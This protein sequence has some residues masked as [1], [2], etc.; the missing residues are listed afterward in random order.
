MKKK[1]LAFLLA[2]SMVSGIILSPIITNTVNAEETNNVVEED[3]EEYADYF[4]YTVLEDGTIEISYYYDT[5]S[6]GII[7]IPDKIDGMTVTGIKD[8]LFNGQTKI[9]SI[10]IP[11]S[12]T[13]IGYFAFSGCTNLESVNIPEGLTEIEAGLFQNCHSLKSITIPESVTSIAGYAFD[14]C[15]SLTEITIPKN[16]TTIQF[17]MFHSCSNLE[18]I[19][20]DADNQN[21]MSENGILYN[22][23]KTTLLRCPGGV[24]GE[25]VIGKDVTSILNGALSYCTG[26]E[27]ITVEEGN[28]Y[29]AVED[30]ALIQKMLTVNTL[31]CYPAGKSGV[32]SIP[33]GVTCIGM[34]AFGGCN[35]LESIE[36]P[37]G[38]TNIYNRAFRECQN[39]ETVILP[40][41]ITTIS[42]ET[43]QNC[44]AL[45]NVELSEDVTSIGIWAFEGCSALKTISIPNNV[46]SI[47]DCAFMNCSSLESITIPNSV[48]SMGESVF[49]YCNN[50]EEIII[51]DSVT[52]IGSSAFG[53]CESLKSITL[54][55]GMTEITEW[56]LYDC[57]W[58]KSITIPKEITS[59]KNYAFSGCDS[60]TD[61]YYSGTT[62]QWK[63]VLVEEL[64][65]KS[66]KYATIHC[67]DGTIDG[68]KSTDFSYTVLDN[69]TVEITGLEDLSE[70][71]NVIIPAKIEGKTVTGIGEGAFTESDGLVSI[72][73]PDTVTYIKNNA[74]SYCEGLEKVIYDGTISRWE[75]I[76][77]VGNNEYLNYVKICCTDGII[78]PGEFRYRVLDDGT[79]EVT[80]LL[81][82]EGVTEL[83]IPSEIDGKTVTSIGESAFSNHE[84]LISVEMPDSITQICDYAFEQCPNLERVVLS[85]A[86]TSLGF[87]AFGGSEKLAEIEIPETVTEI[88]TYALIDTAWLANQRTE[89]PLVII[90]GILLDGQTAKGEVIIPDSVSKIGGS[91]FQ[92]CGEMTKITIPN[93]V[94][95][96]G[97]SAFNQCSGL[98][99]ITIPESVTEIGSF[100]FSA[101]T[102]LEEIAIPD[103]VTNIEYAL[104]QNCSNLKKVNVPETIT[105]IKEYAF[106]GCSSLTDITIPDKVTSIGGWA[107]QNCT[108][109]ENIT[110][111]KAVTAIGTRAFDGTKWLDAKRAEN[112]LVIVN[113]IVIDGKMVQGD[114]DMP[115]TVKSICALAFRENSGLTSIIIPAGIT[116][117][118]VS[119][120]HTCSNLISIEIPSSVINIEGWAFYLCDNLKDIYY[121]GTEEQWKNIIV[122]EYCNDVLANVTIH[123]NSTP[124]LDSKNESDK[125]QTIPTP[126]KDIQGDEQIA[127]VPDKNQT[128]DAPVTIALGSVSLSKSEMVYTGKAQTPA[129]TVF[130]ANNQPVD[131]ANYTAAYTSNKNVGQATV[132][133]TGKN[134]YT[135][136]LTANFKILPKGTKLSKLTAKKKALTIK[137]KKQ[138]KQTTGYEIQYSTSKKFKGAKKVTVKKAK[139][140]S[141]IIKKLKAKKKYYV[142]IR[143]YKTVKIDGKSKKLYSEWSKSKSVKV[144]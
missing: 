94:V 12:V 144:K 127:P 5:G 106:Y 103:T 78:E 15:N 64:E 51:S 32:V 21:Y 113:N 66:L 104:F 77:I 44:N 3:V 131:A 136:T 59:I 86:V 36:I 76:S 133:I 10:T 85:K 37:E 40:K 117:L 31:V 134:N 89:N 99:E 26:L 20:V 65:N 19:I 48:I 107:F 100:A 67:T 90:N 33:E 46:S 54:P 142:R 137:W 68:E 11:D 130:D 28:I 83:I 6:D 30:G 132:T 35:N 34:E 93:T 74:F 24:K 27:K 143:T 110:I 13:S 58:M 70:R 9:K 45:K 42:Q 96:I 115:D 135:G 138:T 39:L 16:V 105:S 2:V 140:T 112:P 55:S 18:R 123:Y 17:P 50:L 49:R 69:N 47:G 126:D 114:V 97:E 98:T 71:A 108:S 139:T 109:L 29:Y 122:S 8:N 52:S 14:Y 62:E 84:E 101:C 61:V 56:M 118:D 81:E 87:Y 121:T 124:T 91:A 120:F 25:V 128:D 79:I 22:K 23:D 60:L 4:E 7:T 75:A 116:V 111:P 57:K 38:V 80:G 73:I 102:G 43:F 53:N 63:S 141:T 92:N 72:G 125:E 41:G 88:D 119:V 129:I 1:I 82:S 95:S